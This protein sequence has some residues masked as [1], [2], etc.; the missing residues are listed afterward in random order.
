MKMLLFPIKAA[1]SLSCLAPAL[2]NN[3][4]AEDSLGDGLVSYWAFKDSARDLVGPLSEPVDSKNPAAFIDGIRDRAWELY[5]TESTAT[6]TT[7]PDAYAFFESRSFTLSFWIKLHSRHTGRAHRILGFRGDSSWHFTLSN[8]RPYFYSALTNSSSIPP[9]SPSNISL[10]ENLWHHIAAVRRP[11]QDPVLYINGELDSKRSNE[12]HFVVRIPEGLYFHTNIFAAIDELAMWNRA[13]AQEDIQRIHSAGIHQSQGIVD[14]VRDDQDSDGLPDLWERLYD[15]DITA[16]DANNDPDR[17]GLTNK[18]E[19]EQGTDPNHADSDRDGLEDGTESGTGIWNGA[20]DRGTDPLNLDSDGD[21][22][23][24]GLEN[25]ELSHS[26]YFQTASDPNQ[27]DTN[28]D[29]ISDRDEE[30]FRSGIVSKTK[31]GRLRVAFWGKA[32]NHYTLIQHEHLADEGRPVAIIDVELDGWHFLTS[33]SKA[34]LRGRQYR[35]RENH[36][37]HSQD[38][39]GDGF[40]DLVESEHI[41]KNEYWKPNAPFNAALGLSGSRKQLGSLGEFIESSTESASGQHVMKFLITQQDTSNPRIY[42]IES[43]RFSTH[44]GFIVRSREHDPTLEQ[45]P[46]RG[47]IVSRPLLL[48]GRTERLY[49]FQF[50]PG[51]Q[52]PIELVQI[53]YDVIVINAPFLEGNLAYH[54]IVANRFIFKKE[55][56]RYDA[57]G[58]PYVT[59]EQLFEGVPFQAVN[60]GHAFGRLR[61]IQPGERP[62]LFDI[63]L[64]PTLPNDISLVAG[65]ITEDPQTPL[66]HVNLRAIQNGSPNAFIP[67][68]SM[69]PSIEPLI[70]QYVSYRVDETGFSLE[71]ASKEDVDNYFESIRPSKPQFPPRRLEARSIKSLEEIHFHDSD[72][73]GVKAANLSELSRMVRVPTVDPGYAVP[74]YFFD[75]F[76]K[77]NDLYAT[78]HSFLSDSEFAENPQE[79]ERRLENFRKTIRKGRMPNWMLEALADVQRQFPEG[80]GIRTRSSTN[81]EDLPGFNGAGLYSSYTHYPDEGHLS[82][83]IKQVY[84]SLWNDLAF[85]HREFYRV[86]HFQAAMG[87]LLHPNFEEELVNGV[88]VSRDIRLPVE[89]RTTRLTYINAQI[90]ENLITNPEPGAQ[91]EIQIIRRSA[92]REDALLGTSSLATSDEPVLTELHAATLANEMG[93][94]HYRFAEFYNIKSSDPRFAM[95]VE[96][97]ITKNDRLVIKQARPW[98]NGVS[99]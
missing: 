75:E 23:H 48:D 71:P 77:F 79:R 85:E 74:F 59:N 33:P 40:S 2:L 83:S 88:A 41:R 66:S 30:H 55:K 26:N 81:N 44:N 4:S 45:D 9:F 52:I 1:L 20:N 27:R 31:D 56:H 54:P 22:L 82:K 49:T 3:V 47:E 65:I 13:L 93:A 42:F 6:F 63:A 21:G 37:D 36:D 61:V 68:A 72:A 80:P 29:G 62:S 78:A 70:G 10:K 90:G 18:E 7:S 87:V 28:N 98:V 16:N 12:R 17:D 24:D 32:E 92:N 73:Y 50:Q 94:I 99:F 14:L 5:Q 57:L 53:A 67:D 95:E 43:S 97:K 35:I 58:L 25:P 34:V 96:F 69:H 8:G 11:N 84:A 19:H 60:E 15:F 76:M 51:D 64:L 46:L 89:D 38:T 91:P 39:D 86:D